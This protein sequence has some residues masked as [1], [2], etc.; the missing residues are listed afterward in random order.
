[1]K[2]HQQAFVFLL[3]SS[4]LMGLSGC[5]PL[6]FGGAAVTTATVATDRRSTGAIVNDEVLEKRVYL[7]VTQ[8]IKT[9]DYHLTVTSYDGKVLLT[10]EVASVAIKEKAGMLARNSLDVSSVVNELAVRPVTTPTERL[11]D[12]YLATK[13]RTQIVGT[14]QI[15]LNQMKVTVDRGIVYLMGIVTPDEAARTK[16]LVANIDGVKEVVALFNVETVEMVKQRMKT[17]NQQPHSNEE[18]FDK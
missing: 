7:E 18:R 2:R 15:S 10:G 9:Q 16:K 14:K 12:S 5:V 3:S 11:S 8:G 17:L 6:L 4:I 1:M 13:V